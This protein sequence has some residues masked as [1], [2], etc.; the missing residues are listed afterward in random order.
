MTQRDALE[1]VRRYRENRT[2]RIIGLMTGTSAD[3]VDAALVRF[4]QKG[5][6]VRFELEAFR[7]GELDAALRA[8][9]LA[10]ANAETLEP[11]RLMRLDVAL[12]ECY[13]AAVLELIAEA[14][15]PPREIDAIGSHGQ[16]VRHVPRHAGGGQALTLQ[17]GS[18]DVLAERTH[19]AVVSGFRGRDVAAGGEG[20]P[21]VPMLDWAMFRND[22][23]SRLLLNVG[24]IANLTYLHAGGAAEDVLAFDTGPG[25]AVLDALTELLTDG[26][27][28]YDRD[29]ERA[30]RGEP[31]EALLEELLTDPYFS[32]DPP[33]STGRERF[34]HSYARKVRDL[35][36][37]LG[38]SDDDLLA[39][40]VELT[41]RSIADSIERWVR[42]RG[43]VEKV[44]VSG[45][46]A[47]NPTLLRSLEKLLEPVPVITSESLG[48]PPA[49][50]EA[51]AF[52][53]LAHRT[54]M[55]SSGNVPSATGAS[56]PVVL[57]HITPGS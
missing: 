42:P 56:H 7:E 2:H 22:D 21:L 49:A 1:I 15:V 32:L 19:M 45:G 24:G 27:E 29:G 46:G 17:L 43:K 8:E 41:T 3:G 9:I 31:S 47:L 50:R 48:V 26:E 51:V 5:Q 37:G 11:E 52:A 16:T 25:N 40:A 44:Y 54:L 14:G 39:T 35:A 34:G 13:A 57:G 55:G 30:A 10:V 36:R 38:L 12:G 23:E 20:A 53:F 4:E 28:R 33:R 6:N 18:A